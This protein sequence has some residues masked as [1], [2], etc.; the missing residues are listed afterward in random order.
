MWNSHCYLANKYIKQGCVHELE[1][2][3]VVIRTSVRW[4]MFVLLP[5]YIFVSGCV[6]GGGGGGLADTCTHNQMQPR[7]TYNH[8]N[9]A[10]RWGRS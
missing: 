8:T 7:V 10:R 1:V 2:A 4:P 3:G 9:V 6:G 5:A